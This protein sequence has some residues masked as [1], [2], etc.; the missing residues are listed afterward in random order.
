MKKILFISSSNI[1]FDSRILKQINA[2]KNSKFK[3]L[4]LGIDAE[5]ASRKLKD[6]E[7]FIF[8][9]KS[10]T[11]NEHLK[12]VE[13]RLFI[14]IF[15][16]PFTLLEVLF[17][18][19]PKVLRF[20]PELI[21]CSDYYLLPIAVVLKILCKS[22]IIYD[23]HEL[24]SKTNEISKLNSSYVLR[25]E[26]LVWP[27]ISATIHVSESIKNWYDVNIGPKETIIVYNSPILPKK[28][29]KHNYFREFFSIKYNI[30]IFLYLGFL[31]KG[32]GIEQA[33]RI[34][35]NLS[36]S[37]AIIFM[38]NGPLD[39]QI[40]NKSKTCSNIFLHPAV[41]HKEVVKL[42]SSADFG[43]CM[44]ENISLSDYYCLPNKL[45][46][47]TFSGLPVITSKFPELSRLVDSY[48]LGITAQ[49]DDKS[50][51]K[52]IKFLAHAGKERRYLDIDLYPLS[53][54]SQEIKLRLLFQ[55]LA[56]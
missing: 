24:E 21:H 14:Q 25:L 54:A 28:I 7:I 23:V 13:P 51:E 49:P 47:Y 40:L 53:W 8:K 41:S 56:D 1:L 34:F 11:L 20:K 15:I 10:R 17:K 19:V 52:S 16:L 29:L 45:F 36:A 39:K 18:F 37:V 31:S 42:S 50:V 5:D 33:L 12:N 26:R 4:A 38:G 9:L 30:K 32:R 55:R 2:A 3:T 6:K 27:F 48:N 44:I 35:S 43:Y 22:K 46:E